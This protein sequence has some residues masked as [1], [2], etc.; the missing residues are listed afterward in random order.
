MAIKPNIENR[1]YFKLHRL[2]ASLKVTDLRIPRGNELEFIKGWWTIRINKQ[3]RLR[4]RWEDDNA[5]DVH[6]SKHHLSSGRT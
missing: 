1:V 4:F 2:N 5:Y 6:I 3:Y